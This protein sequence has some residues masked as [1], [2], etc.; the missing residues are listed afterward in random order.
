MQNNLITHK[1]EVMER[2]ENCSYPVRHFLI[3]L[4]FNCTRNY[5]YRK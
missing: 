3:E 5:T 2:F 1:F 4:V